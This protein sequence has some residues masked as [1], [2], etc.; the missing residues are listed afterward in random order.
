[1]RPASEHCMPSER[2]CHPPTALLPDSVTPRLRRADWGFW[3]KKAG[4]GLFMVAGVGGGGD[5]DGAEEMMMEE[6]RME[7][8][9][10]MEDDD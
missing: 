2:W 5:E 6:M 7:E 1:V 9:M 4:S 8:G 3:R 10:R